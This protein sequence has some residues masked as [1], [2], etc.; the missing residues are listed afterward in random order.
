MPYVFAGDN[1]FLLNEKPVW[2]LTEVEIRQKGKKFFWILST[3]ISK[4]KRIRLQDPYKCR[5]LY[6]CIF[7]A[8][9]NLAYFKKFSPDKIKIGLHFPSYI[10]QVINDV[11]VE[12]SWMEENIPIAF[13]SFTITVESE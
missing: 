7:S 5:S 10:D 12:E 3:Y 2:N 4:I 6:F 11:I 8:K 9:V 1:Q 13:Q